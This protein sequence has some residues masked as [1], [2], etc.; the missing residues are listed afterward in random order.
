MVLMGIALLLQAISR[1]TVV[2]K[3]VSGDLETEDIFRS[4]VNWLYTSMCLE[5]CSEPKVENQMGLRLTASLKPCCSAGNY[6]HG[7]WSRTNTKNVYNL[8]IWYSILF[9]KL[10][11]R[12]NHQNPNWIN[13]CLLHA[14]VSLGTLNMI[15]Q[16]SKWKVCVVCR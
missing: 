15:T 12:E 10:G 5:H 9:G 1:N 6:P 3:R 13:H 11:Y 14:C 2:R 16:R 8:G 7:D 4:R